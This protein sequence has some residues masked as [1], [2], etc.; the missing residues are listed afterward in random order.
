MAAKELQLVEKEQEMAARGLQLV[1]KKLQMAVKELKMVAKVLELKMAVAKVLE[2]K[3]AKAPEAIPMARAKGKALAKSVEHGLEM[4]LE[5][6]PVGSPRQ[7][8]ASLLLGLQQEL[9]QP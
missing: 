7:A 2:L 3:V 6:E 5:P 1:A 4:E 8:S 9:A